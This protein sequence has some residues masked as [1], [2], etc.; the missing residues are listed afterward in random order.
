MR[1]LTWLVI[2]ALYPTILFAQG[3]ALYLNPDNAPG[4]KVSVLFSG[5]ELIP[6]Q[7]S[8]ASHFT[9]IQDFLVTPYLFI[10]LD[11]TSNTVLIFNKKGKFLYKYKKKK[12]S[13]Q[14]IQYV[15][16]KNALFIT[17][18]N[19][20]YTIPKMKAQQMIE[21]SPK[22]DF[23]KYV[24]LELLHL[25]DT[26]GYRVE[27]LPVPRYALN[28]LYYFNGDYLS[29]DD[30]YNKYLKDTVAFHLNIIHDNKVIKSYFP[31]LNIP[32]LPSFYKDVNLAIDNTTNDSSFLIQKQF[33]N[34]IYELT[35]DSLYA[36]YK[37]VFP[38]GQTMAGDFQSTLFK[39]NIDL[40]TA[41]GKNNKVIYGFYNMLEHGRLLF[42]STI[43]VNYYRRNL[44]FNSIDNKLYDL[45]KITTDSV[46]YFL[47]S[48]I[49]S[50]ISEQDDDYVY[51]RISSADLLRE[52]DK[53][54]SKN[55]LLPKKIEQL[56]SSLDKF[57]NAIIIKLKVKPSITKE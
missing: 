10:F 27:K 48:L 51:T 54:L 6:L 25:D 24:S 32:K 18:T 36:K 4:V 2:L 34:T 26:T 50:S 16:A 20:N 39:N 21:R 5:A 44:L 57:D 9:N 56:L 29:V 19:K 15:H 31:F 13:I 41:I 12:Y 47:P 7:T 23:S 49:F 11:N 35:P 33:D 53:L 37:F 14:S 8:K 38:S 1:I 46:L 30:R 52:K 45:G 43:T 22:N 17:A 28:T 42:F 55:K 3:K 40:E